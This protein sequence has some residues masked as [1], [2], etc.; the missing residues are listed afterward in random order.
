MSLESSPEYERAV[1]IWGQRVRTTVSG[2][3]VS[4]HLEASLKLAIPLMLPKAE[5][6]PVSLEFGTVPPM[7]VFK[8]VRAENWL[9]HH[10]GLDHRRTR[11]LKERLLH[12]F[13]PDSAEWRTSVWN[14]GKEVIDR[15]LAHLAR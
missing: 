15:A 4:T 3:S 9:H 1:A 13:Y 11:E 5:V 2:A 14:Q 10:A 7:E 8:A 6:T 12:A